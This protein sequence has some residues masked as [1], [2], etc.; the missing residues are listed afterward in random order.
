MKR[1]IIISGLVI[2]VIVLL[3]LSAIPSVTSDSASTRQNNIAPLAKC[4]SNGGGQSRYGYG[5]ENMNDLNPNN[6][7]WIYAPR[8]GA[9]FQLIWATPYSIEWM[10]I[11]QH[12]VH[13]NPG[14]RNLAGCD[15][16]Y[17]SGSTWVKDATLTNI[18]SDIT[19]YFSSVIT[20]SSIRLTNIKVTGRQ[21]SNPCIYEWY[22]YEGVAGIAT[23]VDL[24]PQ[25]L[26]LESNGNYVQFKIYGFPE[27]PEYSVYD[28]DISTVEVEGVGADLKYGTLN[29]NKLIGKADRLLVEDAIGAPSQEM[30]VKIRGQLYDSTAFSGKAVI[31]AILN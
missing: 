28:I 19:Y 26:N 18:N 24:E 20:T 13:S 30:E 1:K 27:N 29:N 5:P 12:G 17:W 15:V 2:L 21:S 11:K 6:M 25:S 9:Y 3:G 14:N 23:D 31:K 8:T 22:V 10:F 7:H 4:T 16:E